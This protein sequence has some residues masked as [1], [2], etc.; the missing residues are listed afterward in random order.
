MLTIE[1]VTTKRRIE[2]GILAAAIVL[3]S[4]GLDFARADD[5]PNQVPADYM[6][7][8][9]DM[10][11]MRISL[12][13]DVV[14]KANFPDLIVPRAFVV[15]VNRAPPSS[16][17]PLPSQLS[18]NEVELVFVDG[19][20]EP[21]SVAVAERSRR[22]GLDRA[23]AG[24]RMRAEE[25]IVQIHPSQMPTAAYA[26]AT[27]ANVLRSAPKRQNDD[28]EGLAHYK[29]VASY[30]NYMGEPAD[31]FFSVQCEGRLHPVFLCKYMMSITEG[32]VAR[33]SFVDFRL[34]GGRAYAN[35]R[36][37]FVREVVCRY[38]TRC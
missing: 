31:E 34:N 23:T 27:R 17:G 36:L 8:S 10:T 35:R 4:Y 7:F 30:S 16:K 26:D 24:Q 13:N 6:H 14:G 15:F 5:V 25:T 28:F 33:V 20:G 18:S 2:R 19:S 11:P 1:N 38:L 37:R 22:D 29:G 21:W 12:V 32:V 3:A 9:L